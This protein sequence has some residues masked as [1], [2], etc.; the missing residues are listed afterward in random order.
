MKIYIDVA[1]GCYR[2]LLD[3]SR[4]QEVMRLEQ[5]RQKIHTEASG[6]REWR[7]FSIK[8]LNLSQILQTAADNKEQHA[9]TAVVFAGDNDVPVMLLVDRIE[10]LITIDEDKLD[11]LPLNIDRLREMFDAVYRHNDEDQLLLRL[12]LDAVNNVADTRAA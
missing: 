2:L 11:P 6:Y 5:S 4:V 7:G 10:R 3:S 9:E 8:T 1:V 12:K